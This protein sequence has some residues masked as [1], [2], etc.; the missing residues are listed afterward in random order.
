MDK[1]LP[2][3]DYLALA[4]ERWGDERVPGLAL[5]DIAISLRILAGRTND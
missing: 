4:I 2:E 1:E 3:T 5:I